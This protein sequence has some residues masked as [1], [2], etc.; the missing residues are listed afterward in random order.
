MICRGNSS[1]FGDR[2]AVC[3]VIKKRLGSKIDISNLVRDEIDACSVI[4]TTTVHFTESS[5]LVYDHMN[6]QC[7]C[8][9]LVHLTMILMCCHAVILS[10]TDKEHMYYSNLRKKP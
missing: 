5:A 10:L 9:V 2:H 1:L 7:L 8:C 4:T 6:L 3:R